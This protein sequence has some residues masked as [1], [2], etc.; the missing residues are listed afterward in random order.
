[1]LNL[2]RYEENENHSKTALHTQQSCCCN[3]QD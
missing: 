3:M 1:M 2:I